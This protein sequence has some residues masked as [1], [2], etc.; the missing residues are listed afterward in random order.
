[1]PKK[2]SK[3]APYCEYLKERLEKYPEL[4]AVVLYKEIAQQGYTG[5]MSILREHVSGLHRREKKPEVLEGV[6]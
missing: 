3:L 5:E 2:E 1:M 4:T 6:K